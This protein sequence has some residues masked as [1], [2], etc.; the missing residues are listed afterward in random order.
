MDIFE[1]FATDETLEVEGS[2]VPL[3]KDTSLKVARIDNPE[4]VKLQTRVFEENEHKLVD[5]PELDNI[6]TRD[7]LAKSILKDWKGLM[8]KGKELKYSI[9]NA[10]M[11]LTHK[12]FR[13]KVVA[14]AINFTN[15]KAKLD[16]KDAKK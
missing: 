2:W 4:H 15:F 11:L 6:L 14:L 8:Y 7:I 1:N 9:K 3:D 5:N 16:E 13:K 12:D 10:N